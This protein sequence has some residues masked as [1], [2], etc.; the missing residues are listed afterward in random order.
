VTF[1][2]TALERNLVVLDQGRARVAG[3]LAPAAV[4]RGESA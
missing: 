2:C 1:R 4:A 3:A